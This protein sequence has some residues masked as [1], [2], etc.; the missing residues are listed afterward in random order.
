[1]GTMN[2]IMA[3]KDHSS[4]K[5]FHASRFPRQSKDKVFVFKMSI[6]L[7]RS[8]VDLVKRMQ[9]GGDMENSWIMFD[10]VK[11]LKDWTTLACHVYDSKYCKVLTITCCDMQYED[12]ATQ[13]LFWENLNI[14]MAENEVSTVNFK[15][16]MAD[17]VQA[18]WNAVRKIYGEGDPSVPMVGRARTC[19]FHWSQKLDKVMQNYIKAALQFQ[20]KQLCKDYKDAKTMDEADTKYHVIR[21]WWLSS[22]AATEEDIHGLSEWLGF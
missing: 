11:R 8:G 9:E 20:H 1:M 17:N 4:F 10:H 22:G 16:L 5:Y 19:L 13:T 6:D 15:V 12:D 21:S 3:F 7:P 2:S 18:N 14:V